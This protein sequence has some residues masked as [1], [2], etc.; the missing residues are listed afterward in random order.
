MRRSDS[1]SCSDTAS[2]P[3]RVARLIDLSRVRGPLGSRVGPT[4]A[5]STSTGWCKPFEV[6]P[7]PL[8]LEAR[9]GEAVAVQVRVAIGGGR[10]VTAPGAP[11]VADGEERLQELE[12]TLDV[13]RAIATLAA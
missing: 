7:L 8:E 12:R 9:L 11:L 13:A 10:T 1:T 3:P 5:A 2:A 6:G 4:S